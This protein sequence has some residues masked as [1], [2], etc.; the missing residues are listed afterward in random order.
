MVS[1]DSCCNKANPRVLEAI[2]AFHIN[3]V[4]FLTFAVKAANP[5]DPV[6]P[7]NNWNTRPRALKAV[8][9]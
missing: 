9:T 8:R 6:E 7:M 3:F 5:L 1:D 4:S 2:V